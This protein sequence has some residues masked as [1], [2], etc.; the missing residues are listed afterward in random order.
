MTWVVIIAS[1]AIIFFSRRKVTTVISSGTDSSTTPTKNTNDLE[2][3]IA[4]LHSKLQN[5]K[6]K[7]EQLKSEW[8]KSQG[9][10]NNII[11]T[12]ADP[13]F[14]K[15]DQHRW[16][17]MN[18][19]F[20]KFMGYPKSKLLGKSDYEFFP[21]EQADV[22]REKDAIVFNTMQENENEEKFTDAQGKLH[23]ISTKKQAFSDDDGNKALVGII[24]DITHYHDQIEISESLKEIMDNMGDGVVVVDKYQNF[25]IFNPAAERMFG[26]NFQGAAIRQLLEKCDCYLADEKT[27]CIIEN[28]PATRV[29]KGEQFNNVLL[30]LKSS[31]YPNGIWVVMTGR[32][33]IDDDGNIKGGVLVCR[34]YTEI[35]KAEINL[36]KQQQ[37][38]EQKNQALEEA[39]RH[40][41]EFLANMSHEL[42]TPLNAIIGYTTL[43][44]QMLNGQIPEKQMDYLRRTTKASRNLLQLINDV[45]DFSKIEAGHMKAFYEEFDFAVVVEDCLM[46]LEGLALSKNIKWKVNLPQ[47]LPQIKSDH[48]KIKQILTNIIGNAIKFTQEGTISVLGSY[49][50]HYLHLELKDTGC[51]IPQDQLG[52]IFESFKQIDGSIKKRFGGTGL[53]MAITKKLCDLLDIKIHV[54]SQVNEGTSFFLKIP[55][56]SEDVKSSEQVPEQILPKKKFRS[57]A[58]IVCITEYQ[59]FDDIKK[60]TSRLAFEV[61]HATQFD[62]ILHY[63]ENNAI[64]CFVVEPTEFGIN[65]L[66]HCKSEIKMQRIPVIMTSTHPERASVNLTV[67]WIKTPISKGL[68]LESLLRINKLHEGTVLIIDTQEEYSHILEEANYKTVTVSDMKQ[69]IQFLDSQ[70]LPVTILVN[71]F[72]NK[73]KGFEILSELGNHSTWQK[74]P[75]VIIADD[76]LMEDEQKISAEWCYKDISSQKLL[77]HIE[78]AI[79]SIEQLGIRS[80]L[81]IDDNITNLQL[82]REVLEAAGYIVFQASSGKEGIEVVMKTRSD[83]VLMDLAMPDMDGFETTKILK[84][85]SAIKNTVIIACSAFHTDDFRKKAKESGCE[86]YIVKPID[87]NTLV[88][89]VKEITLGAQLKRTNEQQ[90]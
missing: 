80:I 38:L 60:H 29:V 12:I 70:P 79:H 17:V 34:D 49:R 6:S 26:N 19:A 73:V 41:S 75:I 28:F 40:K 85:K 74:I 7:R 15:D 66:N 25:T 50:D 18:E 21:K 51:G 87:P 42:R 63:V 55:I 78:M 77:T 24:R 58:H 1:G 48:A 16:V 43:S 56:Q 44:E 64:W 9:Y 53:G 39:N 22:F 90:A 32:P 57:R 10:L 35:K 72:S 69:V 31:T 62:E 88:Q 30:L 68:L 82:M 67:E 33:I 59:T 36:L 86:G 52:S 54:K 47:N 11:N 3:Q 4:E 20:C 84:Q 46:T 27:E 45:L 8:Q 61:V 81:V 89:Q 76:E 23:T 5:E 13:I 83:V 37:D 14:V 65:I 71:L 2:N